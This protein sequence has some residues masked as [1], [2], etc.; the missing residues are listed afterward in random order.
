VS[1]DVAL[2][3]LSTHSGTCGRGRGGSTGAVVDGS[4][5][6]PANN[7]GRNTIE[8]SPTRRRDGGHQVKACGVESALQRQA[9]FSHAAYSRGCL[10]LST[11]YGCLRIHLR[12]VGHY[13][14]TFACRSRRLSRGTLTGIEPGVYSASW[15][16]SS[17]DR[18]ASSCTTS[19]GGM[20]PVGTNGAVV[21]TPHNVRYGVRPS[22]LSPRMGGDRVMGP[23]VPGL[24]MSET[25][26]LEMG[27]TFSSGCR[28]GFR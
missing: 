1:K 19:P 14:G 4:I 24:L 25:V 9:P 2:V 26:M 18:S 6:R 16:A 28:E 15:L 8:V 21:P 13:R 27:G 7:V 10:G 20:G 5:H 3:N 22:T 23:P 12:E 11:R 17:A